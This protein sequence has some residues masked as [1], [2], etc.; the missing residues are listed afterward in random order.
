MCLCV[1]D[2][3]SGVGGPALSEPLVR[4]VRHACPPSGSAGA[5]QHRLPASCCKERLLK[6]SVLKTDSNVEIVTD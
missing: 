5:G 6:H 3:E 4:G 1:L 2:A